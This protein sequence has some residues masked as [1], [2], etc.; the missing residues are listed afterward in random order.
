MNSA[1]IVL[2]ILQPTERDKFLG[3]LEESIYD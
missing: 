2:A 3:L 1:G